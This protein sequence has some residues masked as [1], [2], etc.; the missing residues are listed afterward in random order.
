[1]PQTQRMS[2]STRIAM[3]VAAGLLLC[4]VSIS[5]IYAYLKYDDMQRVTNDRLRMALALYGHELG[6]HT[7]AIE[8][9]LPRPGLVTSL[10]RNGF[11][12]VVTEAFVDE[13][14]SL[15]GSE[16]THFNRDAASGDFVRLMT[17]VGKAMG[18]R[19]VGTTLDRQSVI[20]ESLADGKPYLGPSPEKGRMHYALYEPVFDKSGAVVGAVASS[21]PKET[22]LAGLTGF[23]SK[24]LAPTLL[25]LVA[26]IFATHFW[27]RRQMQPLQG[28]VTALSRLS[29]R[30]VDAEIDER[31]LNGDFGALTRAC[32][33]LRAALREAALLEEKAA[34]EE[35]E[36][37]RRRIELA[38]VVDDMRSGLAR[39]AEGDLTTRITD[40]PDNPFPPDYDNLRQSYNTVLDR[41][42]DVIDMVSSIARGLRDS[43]SEITAASRELSGRAE[44]QAATLEESAAALTELTQSVGSTAERA[45][46]AQEA[47]FGNRT[48][49][50]RGAGIVRDAVTAMQEI[51]HGSEQI[52]RII[53]VID[54]IA[55]Q[56]NLLALNAGVE[57]ARAGEAGRGFAV[58]ASEVRLLAQR[59]SES[60]REIKALI[61]DSTRQVGQ[62]STLVRRAGDSLSEILGRANE[63]A[64]LVADIAMAAAEQARGLSEVTSAVN[65]LDHVTQQNSAVAEQTSA[66]AATLQ[67]RSEELITALGSFRTSH[68]GQE[69]VPS[70]P[71]P[72]PSTTELPVDPKVVDWAPA[73]TAAANAR[74][75][76][77]PRANGVWAEF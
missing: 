56:T 22:V 55:F 30:E 38:R 36:R 23:L 13:V 8:Q 73:V 7:A 53:G 16:I 31:H 74:R 37:E 44:T 63:A 50:E 68:R 52:T 19:I 67:S 40:T 77:R 54:D 1:M 17:T 43:A 58:V 18:H 39:L 9:G 3:L 66:A 41:I 29:R 71:A 32:I 10:T 42:S 51:E 27:V 34:T 49:A 12:L 15:A 2:I 60:A 48:G 20:Y 72:K 69:G 14:G 5:T 76:N 45:G 47:S 4:T 61:S 21:V 6:R 57:A 59:A 28:L 11:D 64:G 70:I 46:K 62:G 35:A 33:D 24:L 26:A 75:A 25:V 65:Q